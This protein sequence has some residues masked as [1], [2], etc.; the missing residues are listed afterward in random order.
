MKRLNPV[1]LLFL[2]LSLGGWYFSGLSP[3]FVAN[4]VVVRISRDSIMVL[5]LLVPLAAGMGINFAVTVGA[6]CA[7]IGLLAAVILGCSGGSGL[8][9][10][11][12]VSLA[13][14]LALGWLLGR[15][16]NR[17]KGQEMIATIIIGFLANGIYQLI[18]LAGYGRWIPPLNRE[19]MLSRGVGIRNM[20]DLPSY[21]NLM[22]QVWA[23]NVGSIHLPIFMLLLVALACAAMTYLFHTRLGRRIEAVGMDKE[24]SALLGIDVDA[25]RIIAIIISTMVACIGQMLFL[26]NIGMLNVYTAHLKTDIFSAAALLA[27]GATIKHAGVRHV[28]LGVLLFHTLFV[29]SPQ[30]GQ[31]LF[32]NAALGEYFRSFVAYGTIALALIVN[33]RR[34]ERPV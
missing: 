21:R 26:Q 9:L 6:M 13:L 28:L 10:A 1:P 20:V 25:T 29:V 23:I 22:D 17:V 24:K 7:Q 12:I 19:I 30:A 8:G 14:S 3:G 4:E 5:A 11:L 16:L 15:V 2:V 18:F 33:I 34:E 27:G 31:N 32:G